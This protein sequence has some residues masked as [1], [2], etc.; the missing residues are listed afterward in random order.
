MIKVSME[1][2]QLKIEPIKETNRLWDYVNDPK[3]IQN[4]ILVKLNKRSLFLKNSI[5]PAEFVPNEAK[6]EGIE[7]LFNPSVPIENSKVILYLD[8]NRHFEFHFHLK[9]VLSPGIA[10]LIPEI[11]KVS[12]FQRKY[13]RIPIKDDSVV[14]TNFRVSKNKIST[15]NVQFQISTKVIF[16]QFE[17]KYKEQYVG[18]RFILPNDNNLPPEISKLEITKP[19]LLKIHT[20]YMYVFPLLTY[21]K[22]KFIP[23]TYILLPIEDKPDP[24]K[25]REILIELEK[26]A[27]E[28]YEKIIEVNTILIKEKQKIVNISEGGAA[29]EITNEDL[30]KL[31]PYQDSFTFDLVFK[32][33]APIR[34]HGEIK[35]IHKIKKEG[36]ESLLVGVEFTGEGY[37]DFK[38]NNKELIKSLLSKLK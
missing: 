16:P 22:N 35:Y 4:L 12:K 11:L 37:T 15:N 9:E 28:L 2:L 24:D 3:I 33:V 8:L 19:E 21:Q 36:K 5:P 38:K 1:E 34:I 25:E 27:D 30:K 20:K 6:E 23:I 18:I 10:I 29:I 7:F 32:L 26:V 31:I 13:P 14:A 17:E